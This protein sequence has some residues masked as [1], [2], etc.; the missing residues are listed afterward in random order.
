MMRN[1]LA[2]VFVAVAATVFY[3]AYGIAAP[4]KACSLVT[5][6]QATAAL[7]NAVAVG[8][9]MTDKACRWSPAAK[10]DDLLTLEVSLTTIDRF[11]KF[12]TDT[13]ATITSVSD[14]GDEAYYSVQ[15]QAGKEA[16]VAL[17]L[18]KG[19]TAVIVHVFGGNKS[20]GEYQA[21]EKAIAALLVPL[22]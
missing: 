3:P 18:K 20:A 6:D 7:G 11:N 1:M 15:L 10:G 17:V 9:P 4:P 19:E 14:L 16:Q 21:K 2:C 8:K 22:I 13:K 12:K 5:T